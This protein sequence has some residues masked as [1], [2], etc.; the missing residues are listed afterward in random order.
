MSHLYVDL[1]IKIEARETDVWN[2]LTQAAFTRQWVGYFQSQFASL[3]SEWLLGSRV[4]WKNRKGDILV[5]GKVTHHN[6]P[7]Q[8]TFSVHDMSGKFD[9]VQS[10]SDG[11]FYDLHEAIGLTTLAVRQGNFS[12][13]PDGKNFYKT[14]IDSWNRSLPI[15]KMLA[16]RF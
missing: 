15:I 11:I 10:E 12:K 16:E 1:R 3:E 14:T 9:S 13:V 7:W 6:P 2:V 5:D 4:Y 8:L